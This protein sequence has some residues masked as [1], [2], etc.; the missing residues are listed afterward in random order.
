MATRKCKDCGNQVSTRAKQCPHCGAPVKR[1][2]GCLGVIVLLFLI[3]VGIG[4]ISSSV[5]QKPKP[6][7][8]AP[9]ASSSSSDTTAPV[10]P[11]APKPKPTTQPPPEPA[12]PDWDARQQ[13]LHAQFLREFTAPQVGTTI[14]L[15]LKQGNTMQGVVKSLTEDEIQIQDGAATMGFMKTQLS[16]QSRIRCFAADYASLK[17]DAQV[18][19]E[20]TQFDAERRAEHERRL[21]DEKRRAEE[22]A[23]RAEARRAQERVSSAQLVLYDW[24]WSS[25]HGYV[26]V[27][28]QVGNISGRKLQNVEALAQ[29]YTADKTFITSDTALIEYNPLM[30]GQVSPF[31]VMLPHNPM[32]QTASISFKIMWGDALDYVKKDEYD[33]ARQ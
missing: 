19:K 27:E 4:I 1:K 7:S 16:P 23:R 15:Q 2:S 6:N 3:F 8:S 33:K 18:K 17:A 30:P 14:S 9:R 31:K 26:T 28:G 10:R 11:P 13:E 32:M 22:E 29:F 21:A 12:P 25:E 5:D 24:S 20:R